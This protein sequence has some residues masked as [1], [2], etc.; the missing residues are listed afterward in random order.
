MKYYDNSFATTPDATMADINCFVEPIILFLGGADK[1]SSFKNLAK[2]VS[3][4]NVI[5]VV[6]LTGEA[7]PRINQELLSAGFPSHKIFEASSMEEGVKIASEESKAGY[8]VLL[9]TA[10]ASFGMFKNYKE[11][12]DIFQ[13]EVNKL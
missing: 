7:S 10:C 2:E 4:K 1:G 8:I 13:K 6:L 3:R 11:R 5:V 9:S 12:G